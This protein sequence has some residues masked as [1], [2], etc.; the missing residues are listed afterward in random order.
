MKE[1]YHIPGIEMI[2]SVF[3]YRT[4]SVPCLSSCTWNLCIEAPTPLFSACV[5]PFPTFFNPVLPFLYLHSKDMKL[6]NL[7]HN[8]DENDQTSTEPRTRYR[9]R[10]P[11]QPRNQ[12]SSSNAASAAATEPHFARC[13]S[14]SAA[15]HWHYYL[16]FH[17]AL[18]WCPTTCMSLSNTPARSKNTHTISLNFTVHTK[19]RLVKASERKQ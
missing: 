12:Q 19:R 13:V 16:A 1:C 4:V 18:A 17:S 2:P 11:D 14:S 15:L 8:S 5:S 9:T 10:T 7:T 6:V 3:P